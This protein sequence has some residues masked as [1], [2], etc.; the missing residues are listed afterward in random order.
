[1]DRT[2][3]VLVVDDD[4]E[5]ASLAVEFLT[6]AGYRVVPAKDGTEALL[7]LHD[8]RADVIVTDMR[9]PRPDCWDLLAA[10]QATNAPT[11]IIVMT[12]SVTEL[13]H[14]EAIERGANAVLQKPFSRTQLVNAVTLAVSRR[15][16]LG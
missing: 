14:R 4:E 6:G 10:L 13:L 1:M 7:F 8:F 3:V 2:P 5:V 12:G 11:Q 16:R 15:Q 9:M